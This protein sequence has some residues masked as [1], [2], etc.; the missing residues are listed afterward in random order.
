MMSKETDP[1]RLDRLASAQSKLSEQER[2]LDGSQRPGSGGQR[3][4]NHNDDER[5][6]T[7]KTC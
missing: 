1:R 2:I 6:P 7:A 4:K 5:Y 3:P